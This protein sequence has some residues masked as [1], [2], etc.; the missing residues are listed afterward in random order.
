MQVINIDA[1]K[2]AISLLNS[3]LGL[4]D[5]PMEIHGRIATVLVLLDCQEG[6]DFF[7]ALKDA[8]TYLDKDTTDLE[9]LISE[10]EN[11]LDDSE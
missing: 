9:K 6:E 7:G 4:D 11:L 10:L 8:Y 5:I 1:F 2:L 3:T